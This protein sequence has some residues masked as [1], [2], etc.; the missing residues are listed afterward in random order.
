MRQNTPGVL[1]YLEAGTV[2]WKG[3]IKEAAHNAHY[4]LSDTLLQGGVRV[5]PVRGGVANLERKTEQLSTLYRIFE[6]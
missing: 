2:V 3:G 1:R 4:W 6:I 5:F